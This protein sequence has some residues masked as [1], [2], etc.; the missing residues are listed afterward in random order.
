[1]NRKKIIEIIC[2]NNKYDEEQKQ[3]INQLEEAR[4]EWENARISF[5]FV[6]DP[7]LIDLVICKED[8]AKAKYMYFLSLAKEKGIKLDATLMVEQLSSASKW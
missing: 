2:D 5:Q 4:I 3:I 1:M 8:E 7:K 6:S